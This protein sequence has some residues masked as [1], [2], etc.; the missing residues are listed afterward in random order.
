MTDDDDDV[1]LLRVQA[2]GLKPVR[3]TS[4]ILTLG[5]WAITPGL[6]ETP[7]AAGI[8][9]ALPRRIRPERAFIGVVFSRGSPS[10][11][12]VE[13][14][15]PDLGAAKA[16]IQSGDIITAIDKTLVT[17]REQ[18]IQIISNFREGQTVQLEIARGDEKFPAAVKLMVPTNGPFAMDLY[19]EQEENRL[20]GDLS[21]RSQGFAQA[22]EHDTVLEPWLCG[23]PLVDLDG[24]AIGLNIARASRVATYALPAD[25]VKQILQT[26][27]STPQQTRKASPSG[28]Q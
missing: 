25:L 18:V 5:Q 8:I 28:G 23:G 3:W 16:G 14:V 1:A 26:F 22:I 17:N 19:L 20:S 11:P 24:K 4:E 15:D 7:Q 2:K 12:Q 21:T 27:E 13:S 6:A 9:S 10:L